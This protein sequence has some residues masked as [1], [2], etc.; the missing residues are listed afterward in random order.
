MSAAG[1]PRPERHRDGHRDEEQLDPALAR[2][3]DAQGMPPAR[4][5]FRAELREAFLTGVFGDEQDELLERA[6]TGHGRVPAARPEFRAELRRSFLEAGRAAGARTPARP[7]PARRTARED[8]G[9]AARRRGPSTSRR[10][11][12]LLAGGLL[13]AAAALLLVLLGPW[14]ATATDPTGSL[15]RLAGAAP[16][17]GLLVDGSPWGGQEPLAGARRVRTGPER[18]R[19][20]LGRQLVVELGP[21][22]ELVL[23]DPGTP[24]ALV[25]EGERGHLRFAT[26][27]DL[28]PGRGLLVRTR[29]AEVEVL[30]TV[31]G[32]DVY[33]EGTCVCC[34]RGEVQVRSRATG[35][36]Q[37][38]A[39]LGRGFVTADEGALL[40][41]EI[42]ADH[43]EPLDELGGDL[44][45]LW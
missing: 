35:E 1:P 20:V 8:R 41:G 34:T 33:D 9:P 12:T 13:T 6:L 19:L 43:R 24:G 29:D 38:V 42:A 18:A 37:R 28:D 27:P 11:W 39:A 5:A 44:A 14:S 26:G 23:A 2:A 21:D 16:A 30:G 17:Q 36:D 4:P 32:V 40:A 45:A 15:W 3:L 10:P 22:S 7:T 25:F 31:F